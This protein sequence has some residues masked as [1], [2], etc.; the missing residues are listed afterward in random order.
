LDP[1]GALTLTS[2]ETSKTLALAQYVAENDGEDPARLL[3]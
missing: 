1:D 2:P 3:N